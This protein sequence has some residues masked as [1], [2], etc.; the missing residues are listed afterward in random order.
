MATKGSSKELSI[1][2]EE[3]IAKLFDGKRSPSSGAA[4]TDAGDVRCKHLL[5]ECKMTGSPGNMVSKPLPKFVQEFEKIAQEAWAEGKDPVL[6]LR[7]YFP[8]S[9]L[10][11]PDGWIDLGLMLA[12]DLSW[13]E[14]IRVKYDY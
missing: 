10:A 9:I 12:S 7:Y 5:I 11:G 4:E 6:A 8:D 13:L 14:D 1:R 2:H 3:H